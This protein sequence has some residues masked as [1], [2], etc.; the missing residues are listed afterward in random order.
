MYPFLISLPENFNRM[1][2][3]AIQALRPFATLELNPSHTEAQIVEYIKKNHQKVFIL[4]RTPFVEVSQ[5]QP[6]IDA[7]AQLLIHRSDVIKQLV[8]A[9]Q[10]DAYLDTF[11]SQLFLKGYSPSTAKRYL[12]KGASILIDADKPLGGMPP[13]SIASLCAALKGDSKIKVSYYKFSE[14]LAKEILRK[15]IKMVFCCYLDMICD[16]SMLKKCLELKVPHLTIA[17]SG[18]SQVELKEFLHNKATV[19]ISGQDK[20][21][22]NAI[23]QLAMAL[24]EIPEPADR[25]LKVVPD[26]GLANHIIDLEQLQEDGKIEL[27]KG[28]D[29]YF[30]TALPQV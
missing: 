4:P 19:V 13:E 17:A 1:D 28:H 25:N 29:W 16:R 3:A 15:G 26:K 14:I 12:S 10:R 22:I 18:Y 21:P 5:L 30:N 11:Q 8:S 24:P 20:I 23:K 7:G 27:I 2:S 9:D 6:F